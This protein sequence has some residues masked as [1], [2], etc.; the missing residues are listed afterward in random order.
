VTVGDEQGRKR[1]HGSGGTG[2]VL[3]RT[4]ENEIWKV[5]IGEKGR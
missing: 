1:K 2:R 3:K 4:G 5:R